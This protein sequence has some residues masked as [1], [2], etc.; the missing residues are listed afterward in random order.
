MSVTLAVGLAMVVLGFVSGIVL[1]WL[2]DPTRQSVAQIG[3][4]G[5]W[6]AFMTFLSATWARVLAEPVLLTQ[7][8]AA[9]LTLCAAFGLSFSVQQTAA[10]MAVGQILAAI[11]ARACVTP[12]PAVA[13]LVH[14]ALMT[15]PPT[16]P[17]AQK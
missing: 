11:A 6:E 16:D 7:L 2:S 5:R 12:N 4:S 17:A 1:L 15:T 9:L 3:P 8:L 14:T 10:I 13:S